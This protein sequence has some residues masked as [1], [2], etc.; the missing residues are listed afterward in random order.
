MALDYVSEQKIC[1]LALGGLCARDFDDILPWFASP[2]FATR[3]VTYETCDNSVWS[4]Y[5]ESCRV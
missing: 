2:A 3:H 5:P 4:G 1:N